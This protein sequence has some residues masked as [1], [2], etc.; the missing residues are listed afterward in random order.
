MVQGL[1]D[2]AAGLAA[3]LESGWDATLLLQERCDLCGREFQ[4]GEVFYLLSRV[5]LQPGG[6]A[7]VLR[8]S[9]MCIQEC[10]GQ[11]VV[12]I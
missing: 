8:Q 5:E 1:V 11:K 10:G 9:A 2:Y 12:Q 6:V 4:A 7:A 3:A